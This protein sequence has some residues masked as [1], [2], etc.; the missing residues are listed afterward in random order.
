MIHAL[1]GLALLAGA[2]G[3]SSRS[4]WD[5]ARYA[6]TRPRQKTFKPGPFDDWTDEEL[7]TKAKALI[8][9]PTGSY[10][11][12]AWHDLDRA[13]SIGNWDR[14]DAQ[15]CYAQDQYIRRAVQSINA[16]KRISDTGRLMKW[17]R[18]GMSA[19]DFNLLSERVK[20]AIQAHDRS[21][22]HPYNGPTFP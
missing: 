7:W 15:T 19:I 4:K 2:I 3:A 17:S 9:G 6:Q 12:G 22:P 8:S 11:E 16:A 18:H 5:A 20:E 21:C 14:Q 10:Q 13:Y 1:A